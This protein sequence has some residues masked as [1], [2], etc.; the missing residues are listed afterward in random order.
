MNT[1]PRRLAAV[2]L[3]LL[4]TAATA[5]VVWVPVTTTNQPSPRR[6]VKLAHDTVR[7]RIVLFGGNDGWSSLTDTWEWDGAAW[8]QRSPAQ[9]PNNR[10]TASM[11]LKGTDTAR[12]TVSRT[13]TTPASSRTLAS[14]PL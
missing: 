2:L 13:V 10:W 4:T 7:D 12:V 3:P 8:T 9:A 11:S 6:N 14:D 5:Q 1:F